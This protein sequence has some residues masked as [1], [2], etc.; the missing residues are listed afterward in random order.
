MLN[1]I[2][3]WLKGIMKLLEKDSKK[4]NVEEELELFTSMCESLEKYEASLPDD[5]NRPKIMRNATETAETMYA[6]MGL[7]KGDLSKLEKM[8]SKIGNFEVE[9]VEK[10]MALFT[11]YRSVIFNVYAWC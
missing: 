11:K 6:I 5:N 10:I 3:C 8:S 9:K 1:G 4:S 2:V 7:C